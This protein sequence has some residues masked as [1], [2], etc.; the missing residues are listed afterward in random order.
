MNGP[1][2][3]IAFLSLVVL[4]VLLLAARAIEIET[5]HAPTAELTYAFQA[6]VTATVAYIGY[7]LHSKGNL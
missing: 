3:T 1:L 5:G 7:I 2:R 4:D 6:A